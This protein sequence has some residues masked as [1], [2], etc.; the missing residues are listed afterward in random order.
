MPNKE[1]NKSNGLR[2]LFY[3][4]ALVRF[5]IQAILGV[6]LLAGGIILLALKIPGW[7][8][9][10][11]IPMVVISSVFIIYTYDDALSRRFEHPNIEEQNDGN[12]NNDNKE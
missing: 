6:V 4:G 11:G 10:F 12:D 9:I 8:I 7:S 3:K 2:S 1:A 5:V